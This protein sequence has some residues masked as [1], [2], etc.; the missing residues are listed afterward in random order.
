MANGVSATNSAP[1][2]GTG[3]VKAGLGTFV[4]LPSTTATN[5]GVTTV[6][7]GTLRLGGTAVNNLADDLTVNA[8]GSVQIAGGFSIPTANRLFINGGTVTNVA[9]S[10]PT[11]TY[12]VLALD[13][14]GII[15]SAGAQIGQLNVTN[16]DFRSGTEQFAKFPAA[17]STNFSVKSTPGT[18]I[19]QS[20]ANSSGA[21]GISGL[22]INAGTFIC[23]YPNP[24]PNND[25]TGGA[26]Y[27]SAAQMT[28]AGGTL[29]QRFAA[30]NNRTET[31]G[32][33]LIAPGA[34]TVMMTNNSSGNLSYTFAQGVLTRNVGGTVNY[35]S[36]GSSTGT[37]AITTTTANVNGILGGYATYGGSDWA[38]GT[39]IAALG[40]YTSNTDPTTWLAANNVTIGAVSIGAFAGSTTINSLRYTATPTSDIALG[41]NTLTLT[42]G[43]L[44]ITGSAAPTISGGTL[45]GGSGADLIVQQYSAGDLNI[46]ATLADNTSASSLTKS[47]PGKLIVSGAN[48]M[49][50]TNYLNG[51]TVEVSDLAKLAAGPL[52]LNNGILHY[53]G[54]SVSS[55]RGITLN[56]VGGTLD[57]AGSAVVTQTAPVVGGGGFNSTLTAGLNLGDWGGLTKAGSGTLILNGNNVYNGP[58]VV[59][60][61]VLIINGNVTLTGSRGLVNYSGGGTVT[62]FG[63]TLGGSGSIAGLVDVKNGGT[64]APG[65]G[66]GT[67]TLAGG[68]TVE[69]GSTSL[70]TVTNSAA[71]SLLAVQGNLI[72]QSNSTLSVSILGTPLE[73]TTNVLITY[74]GTRTGSFNPAVVVAGGSIDGSIGLDYS[75]PGQVK[76]VLIPQVAITAQPQNTIVSVGATAT[77]NV[78]ATGTAPLNYQWY[79]YADALGNSPVGQSSTTSSFSINN[80]QSSDSG[81]YGVVVSNNFNS[82]TST[83]VFL[84]VGNV[85]PVLAGPTNETVIAGN[86]LTFSTTVTLANPAPGL[87]WYTN[88]IAVAGATGTSVT[89]TSVPFAED[90]TIVSVIATNIAGSATNTATMSVLLSPIISPQPTNLTVNVGDTAVFSAGIAGFPV[91]TLQWYKNNVALVGQN[92][93][94]LTIANAQGSDIASYKLTAANSAG[95]VTSSIVTLTVNSTTLAT[96][97][98][99]PANGATG[100]GYDTPLYV[101]FN[102]PISIVNSGKIRIWNSTNATTPVDIIDMSSNSVVISPGIGITNNIQAHSP[103]SGDSQVINYFPVIIT[104][105]VAAI[106]PHSGVMTSNQ[107]YYV[108]MDNGVVADSTLA[109]FAGI[110]DTNAWRFTTKQTG[111]LNPTNL[112]V[113]ADGTG[114]FVTVQG[115]VD[116]VPSGNTA[117]TVINIHDGNYVEIVDI[118]GKNNLTFRGQSRHGTVVGYANNNNLTGTT[119]ARMAIKANSSDLHFENLTLLNSTPQ[120]GS[121]AESLLI[122]NNGLRCIVNN[123]DVVSRQDTILINASTSTGYFYNSRIIGNFDYIWGVGVGYFYHCTFHTLTNSQSASYNFSAART[124]N[125]ATVS[126]NTPWINPN[127]T[128]S[129]DGFSFVSCTF[130]ADAG[131]TNITMAGSNGTPGGLDSWANCMIDTN[132][133]VIPSNT[134][135]NQYVFWQYSNTDITGLNPIS[136]VNMQTIGV[137]NGDPRLLAATNSIVWLYGWNPA[138]APNIISQPVGQT[139]SAGQPA[140]FT[141]SATGI[142]DPNYQWLLNG[143]PISGATSNTYSIASAVRAN[144]GNYSVV[145]NNGSG[146][147]T[148]TVAVLTYTGNVAPVASSF[149]IGALLGIPETVTISGV[150][151]TDADGDTLTVT[152]VSSAA[153]GT[154]TTD[155]TKV[156]YTASS[157]SSDSFTYTVNDGFGGVNTGTISVTISSNVANYNQVAAAN[158]GSGTNVVSFL[159]NPGYNYALDTATNLLPPI[160][161]QPQATNTAAIDGTLTFTNLSLLPQ[162]FYRTQL[163]Q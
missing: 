20:R 1:L 121:Q 139:V 94:T 24:A 39:T 155:G 83:V 98:V 34:T 129:A 54:S 26:K 114:D 47:G 87:Q 16:F 123:C 2:G 141:V 75:T 12:N 51:G 109:Y 162:T 74:T 21:N 42:S 38:V 61:G 56:G 65:N 91:P 160:N 158:A 49:T 48:T 14:G 113:A 13:N 8:G 35:S 133:Y 156:T 25:T 115:A 125:S 76:L 27:I 57:V 19:V 89:L 68:L 102:G 33:V 53:T 10:N 50:G 105:N 79:R 3:F 18:V 41:G 86:N 137:T 30:A 23:D 11:L 99:A 131:V 55:S 67:L 135:T 22:K 101:T 15:A 78:T 28:Y 145:V 124:L 29:F 92:G 150:H 148:S 45:L 69:T 103:F 127:G 88:G 9:A 118:S 82:V 66:I 80:A 161:W 100:V 97:T 60:N 140:S 40:A 110:S 159:G 37:K 151:A 136:F 63:G 90:Q 44:L 85:A 149:A 36:G 104:G 128:F 5:V 96:T 138:L 70:F 130:E 58:T 154:V 134:L 93:N 147:I 64:L 81:F 144:G 7:A 153:N 84:I 107:T 95:S 31:V 132:A 106:Y 152:G 77:F 52:V 108:T 6:N 4:L 32:G 71:G 116:S 143:V 46:S 163:V 62:V 142:P 111:P 126:T 73:P 17:M 157:G 112:V 72:V 59:S 122:Y 43:G 120:G 117:F 146:T 119:A